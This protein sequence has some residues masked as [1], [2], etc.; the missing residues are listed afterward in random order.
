MT[1]LSP[2]QIAEAARARFTGER[3]AWIVAIGLAESGGDPEAISAVASDGTR[4]YGLFQIETENVTAHDGWERWTDPAWQTDVA[5]E[6]SAGGTYFG[7]WCT[8]C[9]PMAGVATTGCGGY[10]SGNARQ[11]LTVGA[12]AAAQVSQ[13]P[14]THDPHVPPPFRLT[15]RQPP[16]MT[17]PEV[18]AWQAKMHARGFHLAV[19]GVYGPESEA[20][21]RSFQRQHHLAEDGEV[22]PI[23]WRATWE[24][25]HV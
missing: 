25:P 19:D 9:A 24:A 6:L 23:T 20:N 16:M 12:Q 17:V 14:P 22:G 8:A 4:G 5:W 7:P 10:G 15:L 3:L 11:F 2:L 18:R 21:C 13:Q 1:T